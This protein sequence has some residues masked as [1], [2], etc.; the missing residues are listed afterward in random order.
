[1]GKKKTL[2][3]NVLLFSISSFGSKFLSFFLVPLYTNFLSTA[4]YGTIDLVVNSAMLLLP[5][6][7]L[8]VYDGVMRYTLTDKDNPQYILIGI[9]VSVIGSI[10]LGISLCITGFI[11]QD[12]LNPLYLVWIWVVFAGNAL[13][14][15]TTNYLRAIDKVSIMVKGSLLNTVILLSTNIILLQLAGY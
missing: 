15:L 11:I 2:S 5:I 9:K 3:L 12:K 1:M 8:T 6:F 4:E 7:T 10:I 14:S 13:Y